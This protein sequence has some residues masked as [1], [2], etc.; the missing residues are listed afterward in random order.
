VRR[1]G[2]RAR[3]CS[4]A[5]VEEDEPVPEG[6]LPEHERRQRGGAT[7]AKNDGGLSSSQGRR[8]ARGSSRER[9][10]GVVRAWGARRLL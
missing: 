9:G 4:L 1:A 2:T 5:V 8:K 10:K 7:E 6:C 3:R